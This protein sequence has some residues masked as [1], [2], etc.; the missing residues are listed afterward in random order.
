MQGLGQVADPLPRPVST[1]GRK[2]WALGGWGEDAMAPGSPPSTPQPERALGRRHR[3][4][5]VRALAGAAGVNEVETW[6]KGATL[7]A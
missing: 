3:L 5:R 7:P 1:M 2:P 6:Q 4:V